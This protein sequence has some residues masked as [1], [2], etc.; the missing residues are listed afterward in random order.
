MAA[1]KFLP[2]RAEINLILC[3]HE[4]IFTDNQI[5]ELCT[6]TKVTERRG[7]QERGAR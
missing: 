6:K 7:E 1:E 5:T 4:V 2:S 3:S